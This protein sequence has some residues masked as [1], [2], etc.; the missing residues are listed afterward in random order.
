MNIKAVIF[1]L[2]GVI[3]S[4]D[5]FH[6]K[7]W[8]RM[9]D[10][11]GVEFN[12]DINN[13]LR[14]VSRMECVDIIL[15]KA[16]RH[17]SEEEKIDLATKK[18][19]YY[20][21]SLSNLSRVDILAGAR[22]LIDGLKTANIK[23]AIGSSSRNAP[24]ILARIGMADTFDAIADGNQIKNSKPDPEVF[25]LAARKLDIAP[26]E[27]LVVE[28][29]KAGVAAAI[30]GNM[31]CLAVGDAQFDGRAHICAPSLEGIAAGTLLAL[32]KDAF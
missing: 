17:F 27:C 23:V 4:T 15:E 31:K 18:N 3:V 20:S 6:Y 19:G 11:A 5:E 13:R 26:E 22:E 29:A 28:D 7:A 10:E 2:D 8:Q 32:R 9:S 30:A 21:D 24:T 16:D 25:L 12:R 1:D 14:G